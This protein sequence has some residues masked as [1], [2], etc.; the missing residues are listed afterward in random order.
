M[1][2]NASNLNPSKQLYSTTK[3][4]IKINFLKVKRET[5]RD[6]DLKSS[7]SHTRCTEVATDKVTRGSVLLEHRNCIFSHEAVSYIGTSV[8]MYLQEVLS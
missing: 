5:M 1:T 6:R 4:D 3:E 8:P 7:S 2:I